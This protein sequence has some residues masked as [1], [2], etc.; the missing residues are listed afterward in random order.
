MGSFGEFYF[1]LVVVD[2]VAISDIGFR[3]GKQFVG[4]HPAQEVLAHALREEKEEI[5]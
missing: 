5:K 1:E 4:T 3:V 2:F